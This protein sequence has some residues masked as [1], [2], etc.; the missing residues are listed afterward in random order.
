MNGEMRRDMPSVEARLKATGHRCGN[1]TLCCFILGVDTP[2]LTKPPDTKCRHCVASKGCTIYERRPALCRAFHCQ[3]LTD[4][5]LG[6]LWYPLTARIV[7]NPVC[8]D[9]GSNPCLVFEVDPRRPGR[10][11]QAPYFE[12]ISNITL[13]LRGIYGT[14]VR[15]GRHWYV[16]VPQRMATDPFLQAVMGDQTVGIIPGKIGPSYIKSPLGDFEWVE[17][18]MP[19]GFAETGWRSSEKRGVVGD[20]MRQRATSA[21]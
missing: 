21:H 14:T 9:D 3:W 5:S 19:D 13:G 11:L 6:D 2:D 1:C 4:P 8:N 15:C 7:I 10:W 12:E 17:V 20:E 18:A 16:M